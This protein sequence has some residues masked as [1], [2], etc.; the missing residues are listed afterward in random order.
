MPEPT[1]QEVI[2]VRWA[3]LLAGFMGA[4]V[5]LSFVK[6]LTRMQMVGAVAIGTVTAGYLTPA[7][8][9]YFHLPSEVQ[10][11]AA[12]LTGLTAMNLI[13]GI[14]A[15]SAYFRKNPTSA[16]TGIPPSPPS[17]DGSNGG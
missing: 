15:L 12:F 16:V 9:A 4:V 2:G 7:V 10:N 13:P 8:L 5:S 1:I 17:Q 3:T 14:L 6:E 11:G